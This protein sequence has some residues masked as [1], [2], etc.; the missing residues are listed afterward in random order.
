MYRKMLKRPRA[1]VSG[2][3]P[4]VSRATPG[5][6]QHVAKDTASSGLEERAGSTGQCAQSEPSRGDWAWGRE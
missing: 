3:T 5:T 1:P 2:F 4:Q 6:A